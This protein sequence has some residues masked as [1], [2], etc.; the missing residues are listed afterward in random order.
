V[1]KPVVRCAKAELYERGST[2]DTV[3]IVVLAVVGFLGF[4]ATRPGSFKVQRST[5]VKAP[6]EAIFPLINDFRRWAEW[7]PFEKFD[8]DMRKSFGGAQQGNGATYV[9][10]GNNKAGKGRMEIIGSTPPSNVKIQLDFEKPFP[11]SNVTDFILQPTGDQT[12]VTWA[13][14]G[15]SSFIVKFMGIFMSMGRMMGKDFEEGLFNLKRVA[16]A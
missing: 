2:L 14:S 11:S 5:N 1:D 9:W 13:M 3:V 7:S 16:E 15:P 10:E 6:A 12:N 8:P 4:V